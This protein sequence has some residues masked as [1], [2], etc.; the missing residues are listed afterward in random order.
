M[1][2]LEL[3]RRA[4]TPLLHEFPDDPLTDHCGPD[5]FPT[6]R[7]LDDDSED[8]WRLAIYL[9]ASSYDEHEADEDQVGAAY[10]AIHDAISTL[11]RIADGLVAGL[12]SDTDDDLN[13]DLPRPPDAA[14]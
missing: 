1:T 4:G 2:L 11:R 7:D 3:I 8:V 5:G 12:P 10:T 9:M 13:P 14:A 6:P